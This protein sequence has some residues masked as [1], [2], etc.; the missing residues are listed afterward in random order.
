MDVKAGTID[1]DYTGNIQVLL[2][3]NS[4]RPFNIAIGDKIAQMVLYNIQMAQVIQITSIQDTTRG[5]KGFGSTGFSSSN[6]TNQ[7]F[8]QPQE[9]SIEEPC[10]HTSVAE[11][12]IEMPYDLYFSHDPF[13]NNLE[14][15]I[16]IKGDRLMLGIF[17]NIALIDNAFK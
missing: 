17:R 12:N 2:E 5:A 16:P 9:I 13:D 1:A 15:D 4:D 11:T 6:D 7:H 14:I 3:N 10:I 8:T